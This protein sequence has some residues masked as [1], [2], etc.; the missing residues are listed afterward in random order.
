[1][2][3]STSFVLARNWWSL[4]IRGLVAIALGVLAFVWPGATLGGLVLFFGV[5]AMIDG[6]V[7]LVG[8][9]RAAGAHERWGSLLFEGI[10]GILAGLAAFFWP[11]IT[12]LVLVYIVAIWAIA[13]G[14]A[15][16]AAAIRL[17][18]HVAGEWLLGLA[19]VLSVLFG[20]FIVAAPAA[21]ALVITLWFGAY[22]FVFGIVLLALG[23]RLRHWHHGVPGSS[24]PI[25]I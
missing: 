23:F 10:I 9:V 20:V 14:I 17:R 1:M 16:I 19:G 2:S 22:A 7:N 15:E 12:A 18:R 5:Y 13:T 24:A 6:V 8:A 21:G 3:P 4:V 11:L 25:P